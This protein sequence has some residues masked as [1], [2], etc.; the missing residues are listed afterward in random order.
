M[1]KDLGGALVLIAVFA[2]MLATKTQFPQVL[3]SLLFLGRPLSTALLLGSIVL[4]WTCKYRA[5]A[6]VAGLLSVY[7]LKTMWTTWPRS[8]DRRLFLEVGRDQARFDPTTSIDL[9]FAN[10]TVTHNLPHLLVQ[11]SFPEML[12]FPPSSETQREMN[13]E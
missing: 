8:D 1:K 11:P 12:V 5:S 3:E 2:A 10:G 13:G 6:L 4:L 7:L 9:Q